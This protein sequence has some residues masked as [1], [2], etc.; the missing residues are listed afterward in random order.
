MAGLD[1]PEL[2]IIQL[3]CI[4]ASKD[5]ELSLLREQLSQDQEVGTFWGVTPPSR[6]YCRPS[7]CVSG[8][9]ACC[10]LQPHRITLISK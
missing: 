8:P 9:V 6:Q 5:K 3:E 1:S 10:L 2:K 4:I 7:V